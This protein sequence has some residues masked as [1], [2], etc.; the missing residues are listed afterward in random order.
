[1]AA[2]KR[3]GAVALVAAALGLPWGGAAEEP[4]GRLLPFTDA[5]TR[6][7]LQHG[8][9]PMPWSRDPGN[10]VSGKT[11]VIRFGERLFFEPRLSASGAV[12]CARWA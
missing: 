8:P 10:R 7:I 3:A 2:M 12:S 11:E 4:G 6:A 5:E 1:M 9:W